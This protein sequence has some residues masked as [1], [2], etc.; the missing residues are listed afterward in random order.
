MNHECPADGCDRAIPYTMLMCR[1]HWYMVPAPLRAAVWNAWQDG[2]GGGT[3]RHTA[4]IDA[5]IRSVNAKLAA[6][7]QAAP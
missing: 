3:A 2:D 7:R 1:P 5:A 4:A 6:R